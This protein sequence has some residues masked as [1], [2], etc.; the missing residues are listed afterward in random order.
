MDRYIQLVKPEDNP[1]AWDLLRHHNAF[2][3]LTVIAWRARRSPSKVA[4]LKTGQA[5]IGDYRNYGMS[6]QQY[7]HAKKQLSDWGYVTF[8]PTNKGT[9]ATLESSEIY[10]INAEQSNDQNNRQAT[11]EQRPSNDQATT[12]KNERMKEC[13]NERNNTNTAKRFD[14][15]WN[16][17]PKKKGKKPCRDKWKS[18]QLD[19]IAD[20]LIEDVQKRKEK[21]SDWLRGFIPNP[22]T[23][24]NQ[25]RWEDEIEQSQQNLVNYDDDGKIET[26]L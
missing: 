7:R 25:E 22:Q 9:I 18:K 6:E 16:I 13:K 24:L 15:F 10:D 3:L 8:K 1:D 14:E 5:L 2:I 12:N 4:N 26:P 17:Y 20:T 19:K 23:Y 11:D 21:D